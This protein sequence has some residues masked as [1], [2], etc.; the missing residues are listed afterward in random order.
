MAGIMERVRDRFT[1]QVHAGTLAK[2]KLSNTNTA[3]AQHFGYKIANSEIITK[4]RSKLDSWV[5]KIRSQR[6]YVRRV[7]KFDAEVL[8][9]VHSGK[10]IDVNALKKLDLKSTEK[11]AESYTKGTQTVNETLKEVRKATVEERYRISH[12]RESRERDH[13]VKIAGINQQVLNYDQEFAT[14]NNKLVRDY[15]MHLML[16]EGVKTDK[17]ETSTLANH[18]KRIS[19]SHEQ[20]LNVK[21][22]EIQTEISKLRIE[23]LNQKKIPETNPEFIA[24]EKMYDDTKVDEVVVLREAMLAFQKDVLE[25][26]ARYKGQIKSRRKAGRAGEVVLSPKPLTN[27]KAASG[28]DVLSMLS[29]YT[30]PAH[31]DELYAFRQAYEDELNIPSNR[32]TTFSV[33]PSVAVENHIIR[34]ERLEEAGLQEEP[35]QEA[36]SPA[37]RDRGVKPAQD[38]TGQNVNTN[39]KQ[40]TWSRVRKKK[41]FRNNSS[42]ASN[43]QEQKPQENTSPVGKNS[44]LKPTQDNNDESEQV[45]TNEEVKTKKTKRRKHPYRPIPRTNIKENKQ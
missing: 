26:T 40:S 35:E 2:A 42:S 32:Y 14:S 11:I 29:R 10:A 36:T 43:S 31:A 1:K 19:T 6:L 41:L 18:F 27:W 24:L 23:L 5:R 21:R 17:G 30:K 28:Q 25:Y 8:K 9:L 20:R 15:A 7:T 33:P 34:M 37:L 44:E 4:V 39:K 38:D 3:K 45:N 16:F 13:K 12:L 22:S